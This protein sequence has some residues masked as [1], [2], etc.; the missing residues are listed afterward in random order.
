MPH[1]SRLVGVFLLVSCAALVIA[2]IGKVE[3]LRDFGD[4]GAS[5]EMKKA[6]D[7]KGYRLSLDD[8]TVVCDLWLRKNLP[9]QPKRDVQGTLY[10]QLPDSVLV[11]LVSFPQATTDYRGQSIKAGTYTLRYALLPNDGNHL[12]VAPNRDFL[13]LVPAGAD[14]DPT[15]SYKF[16]ELVNL[17]RAATTTHHPAP[18]SLVQA[19]HGVTAAFAKEE[20]L[21]IFSVG[22]KLGGTDP[23]PTA[24]VLKGTAPQ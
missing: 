4:A 1:F 15:R 17:S 22:L 23:L 9:A 6:L 11:G 8:G 16:D 21:W 2:Q 24:L 5:A 3:N 18:L 12:G 13:L 10:S 7:P 19:D 14:P 20:D